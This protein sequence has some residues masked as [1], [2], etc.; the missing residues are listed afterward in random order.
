ME[1]PKITIITPSFNQG[2]YLEETILS[3]LNQNYPNLEYFVVDGGSTDNSVEIIQRYADRITWWVSERDKGQTEAINKGMLRATGDIVNWINSDD[4]LA[5]G[6]L[7]HVAEMF[8]GS[9][10]LC[11]CGPITMFENEKRWKFDAAF[12]KGDSFEIVFGIDIYNQPGT[13]FHRKAIDKIGLPDMRL[14]YV[15]DKEWF[16]RFLMHCGT[17]RIATT[18][19]LLADYR[20][21][22]TTKTA[23]QTDKFI[24][25]YAMLTHRWVSACGEANLAGLIANKF[26]V[27]KHPY[28]APEIQNTAHLKKAV[29]QMAALLMLR[30][31]HR[32]YNESDYHFAEKLN[33]AIDWSQ[34][35][36]DQQ[37]QKNLAA[38]QRNLSWGSWTLFRLK[39]KLGLAGKY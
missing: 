6:S 29:V 1:Y 7:H 20:I 24:A 30:R 21:H 2:H 25:E 3:V 37:L 32:I 5:P 23:G 13:F 19:Q 34:V 22:S 35:E 18:E 15:M 8:V 17:D 31:F 12:K 39:R 27:S 9:D 28:A 11:L 4:L 26:D 33:K 38:M 14:H 10:A 16:M 36:L